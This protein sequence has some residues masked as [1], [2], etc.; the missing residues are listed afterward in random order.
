MSS[1]TL[2][3]AAIAALGLTTLSGGAS[4]EP[5]LGEIMGVTQQ[6]CPAPDVTNRSH[7]RMKKLPCNF[8]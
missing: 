4:A 7:T 8:R 5:G 6:H 1:F 2:L 3:H